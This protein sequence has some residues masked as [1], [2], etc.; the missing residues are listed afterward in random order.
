MSMKILQHFQTPEELEEDMPELL[1][2][3]KIA[4]EEET[5]WPFFGGVITLNNGHRYQVAEM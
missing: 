4:L 1:E 5:T 3:H 2:M